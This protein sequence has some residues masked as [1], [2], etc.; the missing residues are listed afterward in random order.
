MWAPRQTNLLPRC[1]RNRC[2]PRFVRAAGG[3]SAEAV[4]FRLLSIGLCLPFSPCYIIPELSPTASPMARRAPFI[5]GGCSRRLGWP[6]QL[7]LACSHPDIAPSDPLPMSWRIHHR[8][9][10]WPRL[11]HRIRADELTCRS[12]HGPC[13][14][15]TAGSFFPAHIGSPPL[16]TTGRQPR[17]TPPRASCGLGRCAHLDRMR[18]SMPSSDGG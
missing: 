2:Y 11:G 12:S 18:P 3:S 4:G 1:N 10:A 14:A 5:H 8:S 13:S 6:S 16:S 7:P 9:Y 15:L 17:R